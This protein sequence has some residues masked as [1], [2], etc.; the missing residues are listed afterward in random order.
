QRGELVGLRRLRAFTMPDM[1]TLVPDIEQAKQEFFEQFKLSMEWMQDLGLDYEVGI[2]FVRSFFEENREFAS[3]L[4][5]LVQKPILLEIWDER[6]FYF[7]MKFEFNFVDSMNK[8]SA[9]STVQID[10]ENTKRFEISYID[11]RGEKR[12][13][14]MLHASISGSIDR[15]VY[16]LLEKAYLDMQKGLKPCLPLWLCPTQ[17]RFIP[18]SDEFTGLCEEFSRDFRKFR[19]D[20]DDRGETVPK[21]VRDAEKEWIPYIVVVGERERALK[22]LSV[23]VRGDGTK[24]MSAT[25]LLRELEEKTRRMPKKPLPLNRY[26]SKRPKFR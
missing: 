17:M 20:I 3:E 12:Y 9:L 7:A 26:L 2:R 8:A 13:P 25:E 24:E 23:R 1:H 10:I 14:L 21:R 6:P 11:E 5:R 22:K 16:A 15:V 19:V 4:A 18:V